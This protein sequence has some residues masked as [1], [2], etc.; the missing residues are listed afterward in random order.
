MKKLNF[1]GASSVTPRRSTRLKQLSR[2]KKKSTPEHIDLTDS[3]D[4][5]NI[6]E[7]GIVINSSLLPKNTTYEND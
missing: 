3:S 5:E 2:P 6:M 4:Q 1:T 7:E